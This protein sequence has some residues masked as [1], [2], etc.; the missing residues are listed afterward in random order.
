[1]TKIGRNDPCPCGSGRKY[2][3]CCLTKAKA[4]TLAHALED[5]AVWAES[6]EL[7]RAS[8]SVIDLIYAGQLDEAEN[9][10]HRLLEDYPEV[11][12][13]HERLAMIYEAR[14][15][16]RKATEHYRLAL[17][18][19]DEHSGDYDPEIRAH[20]VHKLNTLDPSNNPPDPSADVPR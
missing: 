2:K 14:G 11:I 12:D 9:V 20:Y 19:I 5:A 13:G 16:Q 8:N 7:N 17:R 1:M 4:Q 18:I 10:A 15:D 6:E 3:H